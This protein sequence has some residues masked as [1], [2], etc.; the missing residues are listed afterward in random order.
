MRAEYV[1]P[2]QSA[3]CPECKINPE[4]IRGPNRGERLCSAGHVFTLSESRAAL[5]RDAQDTICPFC[6]RAYA[7]C[8]A[9]MPVEVNRHDH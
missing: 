3:Y 9:D 1:S 5:Q 8:V 4:Q 6:H 7:D 2:K